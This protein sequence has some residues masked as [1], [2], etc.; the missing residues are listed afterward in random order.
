MIE[1][2]YSLRLLKLFKGYSQAYGTYNIHSLG[3]EGKQKP[4]YQTRKSPYSEY[5]FSEHIEGRQPIGIY[6]LD[7]NETVSFAAIDIDKYPIDL[8]AIST[9]LNNWKLPL[10][11]CSSK[12]GGAHIYVFFI[13]PEAPAAVISLLKKVS[14]A[15][16]YPKAEVF[17]KQE[18]RPS[19]SYGS[20]INL[21]FF[22][23]HSL[24]YLCWDGNE[25]M[26]LEGFV[27]LAEAR[28]T[29]L[30]ALEEG[31]AN[32]NFL[33]CSAD[34]Q[35][36]KMATQGG[37]N[38]FLYQYGRNLR[39]ELTD[40]SIIIHLIKTKN[41]SASIDDHPY[42]ETK[43]PVCSN[44]LQ[45]II[46][47]VFKPL[48]G[49]Q[50]ENTDSVIAE[51][52]KCH[53][54]V[55][56]GGKARILNVKQDPIHDWNTHDFSTPADFRSLYANRKVKVEDKLHD[57]A[58]MWLKHPERL[59][60]QG[61]TFDPSGGPS[62]YYNLYQGF[63]VKPIR[64]DCGL[65]LDHI[66]HNICRGDKDLYEY[67]LNWMADAIQN[68]ATRPGV[69]LA[70]RGKQGVGKGI[71]VNVFISLFGPHGIQVTQ[72]SHL[73][74]NFNAH[75][76]DKLLVFA[77]EAFWA[78]DK[79]AEGVLKGLVTED[80]IA[81]EMKCVDIQ[82]S[83]NYVRL[84]LASNN[85]WLIPAGA[86]QRRFVVME[87]GAA[88]MQDAAYFGAIIEQIKNGGREALMF[89]L[90]E[91]DLN[92]VNLRS[93]PKTSALVE[94][95]LHSMD[96]VGQWL[97]SCLDAGGFQEQGEG[98]R[99]EF[100]QWSQQYQISEFHGFYSFYCK[101]FSVH[102][103]V[104]ASIFGK[105][106]NQLFT[107]IERRKVSEGMIR[108]NVYVLPTLDD[109]RKEFTSTNGLDSMRWPEEEG[110]LFEGTS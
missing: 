16:G 46:K 39:R 93:I 109:A 67:V 102:R 20:F 42:F 86:D 6:P 103:P 87:A 55:M 88:R 11:V 43:G 71:F 5:Q 58:G 4:D 84:I 54:H 29:N 59:S 104:S 36:R 7:D 28:L 37:R 23:H 89:F 1:T 30:K 45:T 110:V 72:S 107:S 52:N 33:D 53:A 68:P 32:A 26:E 21:P 91:R 31:L 64:G 40:D 97:Y 74:G 18:T 47:N 100:I 82:S 98:G 79:R 9:K 48:S 69:A 50:G 95:K 25:K 75:L 35:A 108:R 63:P 94:Q 76:R 57:A 90:L 73:V 49:F 78:G 80:N 85:D 41:Q 14:A 34:T 12:S 51:F 13:K 62:N 24:N 83:P 15:L 106:L 60:Y 38:D 17:P 99:A 92:G 44:E 3:G 96:S 70:I 27:E 61:I 105:R 10:V 66:L 19:G 77:D 22:G 101:R 56:V 2:S 65:Y 81:I 8:A